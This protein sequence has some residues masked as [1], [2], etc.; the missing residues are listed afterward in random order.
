MSEFNLLNCLRNLLK[1]IKYSP[2][3]H[4]C[5]MQLTYTPSVCYPDDRRTPATL[6]AP[7]M[8]SCR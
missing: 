5:F 3:N 7:L 6:A 2:E 4:P 1:Q 8:V